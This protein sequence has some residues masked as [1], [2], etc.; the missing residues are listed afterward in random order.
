VHSLNYIGNHQASDSRKRSREHEQGHAN[1]PGRAQKRLQA[2]ENLQSSSREWKFSSK[3]EAD[4]YLTSHGHSTILEIANKYLLSRR[5]PLICIKRTADAPLADTSSRLRGNGNL[6]G[7]QNYEQ[8]PSK[9]SSP[10]SGAHG[11]HRSHKFSS[12]ASVAGFA[13]VDVSDSSEVQPNRRGKCKAD[14][15]GR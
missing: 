3:E 5:H 15:D 10:S 6:T 8:H 14:A 4:A 2:N 12:P 11:A 9:A 13:G 1:Q 7:F